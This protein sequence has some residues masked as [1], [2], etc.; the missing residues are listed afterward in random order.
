MGRGCRISNAGL[1]AFDEPVDDEIS[2]GAIVMNMDLGRQRAGSNEH[3]DIVVVSIIVEAPQ[4]RLVGWTGE[5]EGC[6]REHDAEQHRHAHATE[7]H[8]THPD[9]VE[10]QCQCPHGRRPARRQLRSLTPAD[11]NVAISP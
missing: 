2:A 6:Q 11:L 3:N 1:G 7:L 9:S 4:P 8:E 5:R 10:H